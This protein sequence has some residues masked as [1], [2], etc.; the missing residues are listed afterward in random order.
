M[1]RLVLASTSPARL[2]LLRDGG[3]E[4]DTI[5]PGVDEDALV[6]RL[7]AEGLIAGTADM[8]LALARAKA[9]AVLDNPIARDAIVIGCDSSLEFAGE[10]LGKPH[11]PHVARERWMAMRGNSG[12]LF[13]GHWVIDNRQPQPG[14]L[15]PAAGRV[16]ASVVHFAD[17]T[18]AE[19]DAYVATGEPLKVAG[20][21]TI[22]GLGGAFLRG[23][24]GDSHTVVGLSL[25]TL[26]DLVREL[27]VEYTSLWNRA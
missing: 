4:P 3:I 19:I 11:E 14:R 1:T 9:E 7:T 16:S 18:D 10:A 12:T 20:A 13:S 15:A 23:I 24:E 21:F 27:G 5:A 22:D 25:P 6:E 17:I 8:V 2:R 26:R